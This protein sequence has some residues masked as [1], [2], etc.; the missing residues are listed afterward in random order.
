MVISLFVAL[1]RSLRPSAW[2]SLHNTLC[3]NDYRAHIVRKPNQPYGPV[4]I[5]LYMSRLVVIKGYYAGP[6]PL[7]GLNWWQWTCCSIT[8][9]KIQQLISNF[10][11][12]Q[13]YN[14]EMRDTVYYINNGKR[15]NHVCW[16]LS[17][18]PLYT[19]V[20][21]DKYWTTALL[22]FL[23][24]GYCHSG[25]K[26]PGD[27]ISLSI[28]QIACEAIRPSYRCAL[29][30]LY[31]REPDGLGLIRRTASVRL[32]QASK[33]MDW[34]GTTWF[35]GLS[36]IIWRR[37]SKYTLRNI[38][39]HDRAAATT[40]FHRWF[41]R[42][43][44]VLCIQMKAKFAADEACYKPSLVRIVWS[45]PS[46]PTENSHSWTDRECKWRNQPVR[47]TYHYL[48]LFWGHLILSKQYLQRWKPSVWKPMAFSK[49]FQSIEQDSPCL[50]RKEK[51]N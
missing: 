33:P 36:S 2:K 21:A 8:S 25:H 35:G 27:K 34:N 18:P 15:C 40:I 4:S 29:R 10:L 23:R 26:E 6:Q 38:R 20:P 44:D 9:D 22:K 1:F 32:Y 28:A 41:I 49:L 48:N 47:R 45:D 3:C 24:S 42:Q 7:Q 39:W 30:T 16:E 13:L 37:H 50:M 14:F 12:S 46:S 51:I 5:P 31:C 43:L 17:H 19:S 11:Y